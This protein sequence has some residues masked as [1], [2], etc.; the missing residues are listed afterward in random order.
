MINLAM[1]TQGLD[2][3]VLS[4]YYLIIIFFN[5]RLHFTVFKHPQH[6]MYNWVY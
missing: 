5:K 6:V 1:S 4:L 3:F 2:I